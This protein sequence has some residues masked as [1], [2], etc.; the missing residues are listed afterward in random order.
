MDAATP[1][2]DPANFPPGLVSTNDKPQDF[3]VGGARVTVW[4]TRTSDGRDMDAL[5]ELIAS[6]QNS[7]LFLMF[8]PG[9][10]GLHTLAGQRA[11]EEKMYVRAW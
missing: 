6:A 8:T 9:P 2:L 5:R 3:K 1:A 11:N 7:I 10:D 4:F